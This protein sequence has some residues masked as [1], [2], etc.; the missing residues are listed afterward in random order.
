MVPLGGA[1]ADKPSSSTLRRKEGQ[2]EN[3][4][5]EPAA[6]SVVK[7]QAAAMSYSRTDVRTGGT[8][9]LFQVP[10]PY[11]I[12]SDPRSVKVGIAE[13]TFPAVFRHSCVPKLSPD[14][15]LKAV[16]VNKSAYPFLAGPTAVFLD[17]AYVAAASM[18]LVPAGQEFTSF[19]GVDQSVKVERKELAHRDETTGVFG[20]KTLRTVHDHRFKVTNGKASEIDLTIADQLPLSQHEDIKVVLEEPRH[21]KDTEAFRRTEQQRLEWRLR[22][23]AGQKTDLP[24]RFAVERPE[25]VLIVGQ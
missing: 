5:G 9:A 12:P 4:L 19:L 25:D 14:V 3:Q 6:L 22:L 18:D 10:R 16:A 2:D 23:A 13:E 15:Y 1:S 21:D 11:D 24:F 7:N 8:A 17:G 20:R